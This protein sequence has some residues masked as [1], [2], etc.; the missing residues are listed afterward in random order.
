MFFNP[1]SFGGGAPQAPRMP[2]MPIHQASNSNFASEISQ[3][4]GDGWDKV[5]NGFLQGWFQD[6][7]QKVIK[8]IVASN[9]VLQLSNFSNDGLKKVNQDTFSSFNVILCLG[10]DSLYSGINLLQNSLDSGGSS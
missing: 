6:V 3:M 8:D 2:P 1:A 7:V 4:F 9:I 10:N 5:L